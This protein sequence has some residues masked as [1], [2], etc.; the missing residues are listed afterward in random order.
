MHENS[1]WYIGLGILSIFLLVYVYFKTKSTRF[2]LLFLAMI[3]LGFL[4]ETVIY[5]FLFSYQYFP[6]LIMHDEIYD[7][8]LGA[9]SSNALAL[10][11]VATFIAVFP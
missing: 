11:A 8:N 4:I 2:L 5:N 3:G 10:P 1:Y 9:I 6:K 7:S